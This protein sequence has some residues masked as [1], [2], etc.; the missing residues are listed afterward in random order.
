MFFRMIYY[1]PIYINLVNEGHSVLDGEDL[2]ISDSSRVQHAMH[3][4][5]DEI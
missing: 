2:Q 4:L 3:S 1:A 5:Q